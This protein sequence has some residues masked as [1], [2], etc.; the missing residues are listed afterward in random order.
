MGRL[1]RMLLHNWYLKLLSLAIAF[2]LW[3][4]YTAEP[5]AEV[6]YLVPLE[7]RNIPN[8]LELS[9]DIPTQIHVRVRG[10]SAIFRR[11]SA[12]DLGIAVDLAGAEPGETLV[13]LGAK[14]V[15]LPPGVE[16]VRISPAEFRLRLVSRAANH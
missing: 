15:D 11:L 13:R 12:A 2:L 6:G 5:V 9:G 3:A 10:R 14:H 4:A 1:R 7:F 8:G 16:L